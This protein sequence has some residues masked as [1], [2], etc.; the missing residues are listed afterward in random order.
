MDN[1]NSSNGDDLSP[2]S[3]SVPSPPQQEE[4][5]EVEEP[6]SATSAPTSTAQAA[7]NILDH[8]TFRPVTPT[9]LPTIIELENSSYPKDEAASKQQLQYR[10]HHAAKF[11]RC[12]IYTPP[13]STS[14]EYY[15]EVE[16][17][18]VGY[19]TAT[20]CSTFTEQ[21]M[22]VH[23]SNGK[24]LAIHSVVVHEQYRNQGIGRA[25]VKYYICTME[26]LLGEKIR[27]SLTVKRKNSGDQIAI[28]GGILTNH[29][30]STAAAVVVANH[31]IPSVSIGTSIS[32]SSSPIVNGSGPNNNSSSNYSNSNNISSGSSGNIFNSGST[33]S[34]GGKG[35]TVIIGGRLIESIVLLSKMSK[36]PFYIKLGFQ[37]LGKSP[38]VHGEEDWYE[39]MK[40]IEVVKNFQ[41]QQKE[42]SDYNNR[43]G[44]AGN[45]LCWIVDS[46]AIP[47]TINNI[48]GCGGDAINDNIND[49]S[50]NTSNT[51]NNN[52]N[53]INNNII[54]N[55]IIN[56]NIINNNNNNNSSKKGSGN[57]AA[58]V[59]IPSGT[60]KEE[61]DPTTESNIT[62]MKNVAKEFNL[63]ET[64]FV[65]KYIKPATDS[66]DESQE[67]ESNEEDIEKSD[68][69]VEYIIRFYTRNGTE[70][71]L[72][73]HA[74]LAA[75]SMIFEYIGK[76][77]EVI[78]DSGG[79]APPI[80]DEIMFHAKNGV[81]LRAK[82]SR[83]V[84]T[85]GNR[86]ASNFR[87][88][89]ITMDFPTKQL[90]QY[91]ERS[92]EYTDIVA[93]LV[94][95]FFMKSTALEG[96]M[97]VKEQIRCI[98]LDDV[99]DDL[100]IELSPEA[101]Y[102]LPMH[103]DDINFKPMLEY[104]GYNRGIMLCCEGTAD[105]EKFGEGIDFQSRFFGPKVGI[106]EDPVTG[107]AHCVLGP[108]YS[109]K[110]GKAEIVGAQN[111]LRG[112]IVEC[113]MNTD[114]IQ[115]TGTAVT[116]MSAKLHM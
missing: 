58:V 95:A 81:I 100:L 68:S 86:M 115:I 10:Q 39:C 27:R 45:Y 85:V 109:A 32:R 88:A 60:T 99:G 116:S 77:N 103:T 6:S 101:F 30:T 84:T 2:P 62:W 37:V 16:D 80:I 38:I 48:G 74:T 49:N 29:A 69:C 44:C 26:E 13:S 8:I 87:N 21:T 4:D 67:N 83:W 71:D 72:C 107:S 7:F 98:G 90:K 59:L 104:D 91:D 79:P 61:F 19:I 63:S 110:L 65:W 47:A 57:P 28:T 33:G 75:S 46:F 43:N 18:I 40:P 56:N 89:K 113:V 5:T 108:Y 92:K 9:D 82:P 42:Q 76:E 53:I 97:N 51:S 112:G 52:N 41:S 73:G 31:N 23:D 105:V 111:S 20:R 25:M 93:M 1:S 11:F 12:A 54:Y 55:N 66:Q 102:R 15:E 114:S 14:S 3:D 78:I 17:I 36:V 64:V 96:N 34:S 35:T 106:K 24:L 70:V 50:N 22:S 94:A